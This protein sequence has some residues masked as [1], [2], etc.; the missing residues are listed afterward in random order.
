MRNSN[1]DSNIYWLY[2]MLDGGE[3]PIY[4]ANY[5]DERNINTT[6]NLLEKELKNE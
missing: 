2:R 5:L 3:D 6:C 4:I 1:V